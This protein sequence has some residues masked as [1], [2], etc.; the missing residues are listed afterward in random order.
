MIMFWVRDAK[1]LLFM[2]EVSQA[3]TVKWKVLKMGIKMSLVSICMG[4]CVSVC[5]CVS[6]NLSVC[7]SS[8]PWEKAE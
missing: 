4:G 6:V 1:S 7:E 5:V 8:R 2:H 3:N